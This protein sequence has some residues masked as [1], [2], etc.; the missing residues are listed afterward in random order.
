M[1]FHVLLKVGY[2]VEVGHGGVAVERHQP[3]VLAQKMQH[4]RQLFAKKE[5]NNGQREGGRAVSGRGWER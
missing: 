2:L 5:P 4:L 3:H 1:F